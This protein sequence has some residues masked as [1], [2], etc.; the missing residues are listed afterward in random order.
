MSMSPEHPTQDHQKH[1]TS[2]WDQM[3]PRFA[4]V[5]GLVMAIALSSVLGLGFALTIL[6]KSPSA[7][8]G[9]VAQ[10][11]PT[12]SANQPQVPSQAPQPEQAGP[13]KA[14]DPKVDHIRGDKNAKV[15]VIEYSDFECPFCIR[16][17]PTMQKLVDEY[18]GKVAWVYRHF[19]LSF[20]QNAQK[21]AE[22]SECANELGGNDAFWKFADKIFERTKGNGT[23]FALDQLAPLAKEIGL[24]EGKFKTCLDSGKYA[25]KVQDDM[26]A[27]STA[28]V[29]GTPGNIVWTKDG[30]S[31]LVSGAV[32]LEALKAVIDPLLK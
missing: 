1:K 3:P 32:P 19:P 10:N 15:F 18:K 6:L 7:N 23:G 5:F 17:H 9:L 25:Q 31:Q 30:K 4:F 27:G 16:H 24:D 8:A 28:G 29:N 20:H 26:A 13:V 12:P 11:Y 22:A 21:E 2:L 14:V